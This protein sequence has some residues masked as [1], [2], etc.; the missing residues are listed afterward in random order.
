MTEGVVFGV[1]VGVFV[2]FF[3]GVNDLLGSGVLEGLG[4]G[5]GQPTPNSHTVPFNGATT[6]KV[7]VSGRAVFLS[8]VKVPEPTPVTREHLGLHHVGSK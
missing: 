4:P 3:V 8:K 1:F 2:G 7:M 5:S 6:Y